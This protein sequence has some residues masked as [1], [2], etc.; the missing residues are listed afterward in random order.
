MQWDKL[1]NNLEIAVYVGPQG[2]AT[3]SKTILDGITREEVWHLSFT[4]SC[5]RKWVV[6]LSG[7]IVSHFW[8]YECQWMHE[9][10]KLWNQRTFC[11]QIQRMAIQH[12]YFDAVELQLIK[13]GLSSHKVYFCLQMLANS[14]SF[15]VVP[16][17]GG[18]VCIV[19]ILSWYRTCRDDPTKKVAAALEVHKRHA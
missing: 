17:L 3:F 6:P 13:L 8:M 12:L 9:C 10:Q 5:E 14:P 11:T 2:V 4:V 15:I 19:R 18:A 16:Y 7:T 1:V